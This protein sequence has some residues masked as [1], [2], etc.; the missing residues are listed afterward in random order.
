MNMYNYLNIGAHCAHGL[1]KK[2]NMI[3]KLFVTYHEKSAL[4]NEEIIT[5]I[6]VGREIA[7]GQFS[8]MMGDDTG[9]NISGLYPYYGRLTGLYWIWKNYAESGNPDYV[10][11]MSHN[12]HFIFDENYFDFSSS[13]KTTD[14][15]SF[16]VFPYIDSDYA[17]KI[18]I[19]RDNISS[20]LERYD[21]IIPKK[22]NSKVCNH[23]DY[24]TLLS[25]NHPSISNAYSLCKDIIEELYPDYIATIDRLENNVYFYRYNIFILNKELFF[26]YCDFLFTILQEVCEKAKHS[27]QN[28]Q[29]IPV[30]AEF[31]FSLFI[32]K[33]YESKTYKIAELYTSYVRDTYSP[34]ELYPIW[35]DNKNVIAVGCSNAYAPYLGVYVQSIRDHASSNRKYDIVVLESDISKDNK[36]KLRRIAHCS[37]INI[38]FYNVD[39]LFSSFNPHISYAY[40]SKHCYYRLAVGKIFK[41]FEKVIFTDIDLA[42]NFDIATMFD[43]DMEGMPIAACEEILWNKENRVGKKQLGW[44]VEE[45]IREVVKTSGRYYNT[46]VMIVDIQKF[47]AF[48][49][50][51]S[52]MKVALNNKFINQEQ[53]VLNQLFNEKIKKLP[54]IYNFEIFQPIYEGS[55]ASYKNYMSYVDTAKIYHFLTNHKVWF[56]PSLPKGY[57]WWDYAKRTPF[58]EEILQRLIDFRISKQPAAS[59]PQGAGNPAVNQLRAELTS[60]H[61]PNINNRFSQGE[62]QTKLLYVMEHP[63]HFKLLKI[64]YAIQ[65][66][67]TFGSIHARY[68]KKYDAA[69]TLLKDARKFKK[70]IRH[71]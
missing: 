15:H 64:K 56:K 62:Y 28:T 12:R 54:L 10:G 13:Y 33:L 24:K 3:M 6:Q 43:I 25:S 52:L 68:Q 37:N 48:T 69:V 40:F 39:W 63:T 66:A 17:A 55:S 18:G 35:E 1:I 9:T 46:G 29:T 14:G 70:Q 60:T 16:F 21:A 22:S 30:L 27:A 61:F 34:D 47:N 11:I 42:V 7:C 50:F 53:C 5:P 36:D 58:Y 71:V 44:N 49:T 20:L 65:K 19:S 59:A 2:Y 45:Y 23:S 41:E 4:L 51:E 38:R 32:L 26:K 67:F 31:L 57:I 8:N